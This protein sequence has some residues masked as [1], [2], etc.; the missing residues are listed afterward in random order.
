MFL[1]LK[2]TQ[3]EGPHTRTPA[4]GSFVTRNTARIGF[5]LSGPSGVSVLCPLL[6]AVLVAVPN[7]RRC[8][9]ERD[10]GRARSGFGFSGRP[11]F[12]DPNETPGSQPTEAA[13]AK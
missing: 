1:F 3:L 13:Q 2:P 6:M 12:G 7:A 10:T 4:Q 11:V 8:G 5:P 9:S